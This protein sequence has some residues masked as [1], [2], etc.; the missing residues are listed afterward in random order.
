MGYIRERKR[1]EK[2]KETME[3]NPSVA[4]LF[5]TQKK[6]KKLY[7]RLE[8]EGWNPLFYGNGPVG[9]TISLDKRLFE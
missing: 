7:F 8:T 3:D 4:G 5:D 1:K 6:Y 2:A 9:E